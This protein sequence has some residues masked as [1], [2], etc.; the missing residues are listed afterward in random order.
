ML[1]QTE[2]VLGNY[3]YYEESYMLSRSDLPQTFQNVVFS[4]VCAP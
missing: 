2:S 3:N 1:A 4:S